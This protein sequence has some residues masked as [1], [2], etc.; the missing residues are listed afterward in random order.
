MVT[1]LE[2]GTLLT[3][4]DSSLG[5]E[6]W[7]GLEPNR[8]WGM[9]VN[10]ALGFGKPIG[11]V[12]AG[13]NSDDGDR[14]KEAIRGVASNAAAT[15]T[16]LPAGYS[17]VRR[18]M[19]AMPYSSDPTRGT[20]YEGRTQRLPDR[21]P[22]SAKPAPPVAPRRSRGNSGVQGRARRLGGNEN[23][24]RGSSERDANGGGEY[25]KILAEGAH[26]LGLGWNANV[27]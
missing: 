27:T 26:I 3:K 11:G 6:Q 16:A 18:P 23:Q 7:G 1:C 2:W 10:A 21:P 4:L 20:G 5:W 24:S 19:D 22:V 17:L 12:D 13:N 9:M 8:Q 14:G 15:P 25:S